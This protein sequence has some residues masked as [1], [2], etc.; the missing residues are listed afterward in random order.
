LP[1][2]NAIFASHACYC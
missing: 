2:Q 1:Q